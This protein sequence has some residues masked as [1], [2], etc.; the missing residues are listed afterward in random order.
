MDGQKTKTEQLRVGSRALLPDGYT[1]IVTDN[2]P[3][4]GMTT[5]VRLGEGVDY[6]S[7]PSQGGLVTVATDK[8]QPVTNPADVLFAHPHSGHPRFLATTVGATAVVVPITIG[9]P[10]AIYLNRDEITSLE[11]MTRPVAMLRLSGTEHVKDRAEYLGYRDVTIEVKGTT[12]RFEGWKGGDRHRTEVA[13]GPSMSTQEALSLLWHRVHALPNAIQ[14]PHESVA[15]LELKEARA[16]LKAAQD[17]DREA[18]SILN[19]MG[20]PKGT[21]AQKIQS[22]SLSEEGKL[23]PLYDTLAELEEWDPSRAQETVIEAACRVLREYRSASLS[24]ELEKIDKVLDEIGEGAEGDETIAEAACRSLRRPHAEVSVELFDAVRAAKDYQKA[25]DACSGGV[26]AGMA[27]KSL[28]ESLW[29]RL[30]RV[31]VLENGRLAFEPSRLTSLLEAIDS[32]KAYQRTFQSEAHEDDLIPLRDDLWEK[33]DH[34]SVQDIDDLWEKIDGTLVDSWDSVGQSR[35]GAEPDLCAQ[36]DE[37]LSHIPGAEGTNILERVR[38]CVGLLWGRR[39]RV[40][41]LEIELAR[42][43]G[44]EQAAKACADMHQVASPTGAKTQPA[45]DDAPPAEYQ[46]HSFVATDTG[47]VRLPSFVLEHI[48]AEKDDGLMY[49]THDKVDNAVVIMSESRARKRL[50]IEEFEGERFRDEFKKGTQVAFGGGGSQDHG[51]VVGYKGDHLR[52]RLSHGENAGKSTLVDLRR[53]PV[54]KVRRCFH[55]RPMPKRQVDEQSEGAEVDAIML[56]AI[57]AAKDYQRAFKAGGVETVDAVRGH[58]QALWDKLDAI[59]LRAPSG[60]GY[61]SRRPIEPSDSKPKSAP[62]PTAPIECGPDEPDEIWCWPDKCNGDRRPNNASWSQGYGLWS[63]TKPEQEASRHRYYREGI[64][65]SWK[66]RHRDVV[67]ERDHLKAKLEGIDLA[68]GANEGTSAIKAPQSVLANGGCV[69]LPTFV[70]Q[71][72]G[73]E[74]GDGVVFW[75]HDT[76]EHAMVIVSNKTAI[77]KLG[78]DSSPL[79]EQFPYGSLLRFTT[80]QGSETGIVVNYEVERGR[81]LLRL[82]LPGNRLAIVN[83]SSVHVQKMERCP[84]FY[85]RHGLQCELEARHACDHWASV[86][87][88]QAEEWERDTDAEHD[89]NRLWTSVYARMLPIVA[90][91]SPDLAHDQARSWA[92]RAVRE[93]YNRPE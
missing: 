56:D 64:V 82:R 46:Q 49:W 75:A 85:G 58:R 24:D 41:R 51:V 93:F 44:G 35:A 91:E 68:R 78:W 36:A 31:T 72:I 74:D 40:E 77:K 43:R 14:Q 53:V 7:A 8:L 1:G 63:V 18:R 2:N 25:F 15:A 10:R 59:V 6:S 88:Q 19:R 27:L 42:L 45:Q 70:V 23:K 61:S 33:L 30:D 79:S 3:V 12:L 29:K 55:P 84:H 21:L 57:K 26:E 87:D 76:I 69:K 5:L 48:G 89:A 81:D 50:G 54:R 16:L 34:V 92:N 86:N 65:E 67:Y 22:V 52:V 66:K 39:Q 80:T 47:W 17:E 9:T 62:A 90:K 60:V 28:R 38:W 73:A 20:A 37:V 71:H 11:A 32:A 4:L 83:P 13:M